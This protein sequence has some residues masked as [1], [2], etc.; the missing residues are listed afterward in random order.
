[1]VNAP[2]NEIERE[3]EWKYFSK[4]ISEVGFISTAWNGTTEVEWQVRCAIF[5]ASQLIQKWVNNI[6]I[7]RH[8][9]YGCRYYTGMF[10]LQ[11]L[12]IFETGSQ[13]EIAIDNI[14]KNVYKH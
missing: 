6:T 7:T 5:A 2:N 10:Y 13:G 14:G 12:L 4:N 1:M 8:D 3:S 11:I 9:Y